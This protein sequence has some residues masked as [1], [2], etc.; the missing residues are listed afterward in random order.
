MALHV[1]V[2]AA[3]LTVSFEWANKRWYE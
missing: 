1:T 3:L 2:F